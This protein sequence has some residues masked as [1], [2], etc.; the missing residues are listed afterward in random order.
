MHDAAAVAPKNGLAI[1]EASVTE[2]TESLLRSHGTIQGGG[3]SIEARKSHRQLQRST[4]G[5]C[6]LAYQ[7]FHLCTK[8]QRRGG[9]FTH[10][11]NG[12]GRGAKA[13]SLRERPLLSER[14][15]ERAA[16]GITGADRVDC[17]DRVRRERQVE[18]LRGHDAA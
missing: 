4:A 17:L 7:F 13:Q 8:G 5:K 18:I 12:A 11:R 2:G 10:N 15:S 14:N 1:G 9:P 16:E 6:S 3:V